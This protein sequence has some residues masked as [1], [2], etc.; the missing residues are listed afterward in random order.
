[1]HDKASFSE[2]DEAKGNDPNNLQQRRRI[3]QDDS[4]EDGGQNYVNTRGVQFFEYKY[5]ESGRGYQ[6]SHRDLKRIVPRS[7]YDDKNVS[8]EDRDENFSNRGSGIGN[9][10]SQYINNADFSKEDEEYIHHDAGYC[11][12]E[13]HDIDS[14]PSKYDGKLLSDTYLMTAFLA[15]QS[16]FQATADTFI[17]VL[18]S[19]ESVMEIAKRSPHIF[20]LSRECVALRPN[21][22]ICREYLGQN[23]CQ[24]KNTCFE[25][26]ICDEFISNRCTDGGCI[27]GHDLHTRHNK[28]ALERFCLQNVDKST[29]RKLIQ[30]QNLCNVTQI[31]NNEVV[32]CDEYNMGNCRK[33]LCKELHICIDYLVGL[34]TCCRPSCKLSHS[35]RL[36]AKFLS[37]Y[38]IDIHN[39]SE[40]DIALAIVMTSSKLTQLAESY[41]GNKLP[42]AFQKNSSAAT[43]QVLENTENSRTNRNMVEKPGGDKSPSGAKPF[44]NNITS[45][46]KDISHCNRITGYQGTTASFHS[47][48]SHYS[49]GDTEIP[50]IC[51]MAV[52]SVCKHEEAGCKR[53][54]AHLPFHWQIKTSRENGWINLQEHQVLHLE[55]TYCDPSEDGT[56]LPPPDRKK[57]PQSIA[58]LIGHDDTRYAN[59]LLMDLQNKDASQLFQLRRLSLQPSDDDKNTDH[60]WYYK[61]DNSLWLQY[62]NIEI[63]QKYKRYKTVQAKE[64][65]VRYKSGSKKM[66]FRIPATYNKYELNFETMRQTNVDTRVMREVRR[67]PLPKG[68][69]LRNEN[70]KILPTTS[71][72]ASV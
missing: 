57:S 5:L 27:M 13:H 42:K 39:K 25:L 29:V 18:G 51:R 69:I 41:G 65:E 40:Y 48:W 23:G 44:L 26:H 22:T 70:R 16:G 33:S 56:V 58:L 35:L 20:H 53:L 12:N 28:R 63:K 37:I 54:H 32:I 52:K 7:Q 61:D 15:E 17:H 3:L 50:E 10:Q 38:G 68:N 30:H 64:I 36:C 2:E 55:N 9:F 66:F 14:P 21:I 62:G 6:R 24:H 4:S 43:S 60:F 34:T 71:P 1:M 49:G 31:Y 19:R 67:R 72:M 11:A 46:T 59:F 45:T 47:I 8:S